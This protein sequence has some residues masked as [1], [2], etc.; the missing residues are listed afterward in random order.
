MERV[1][2]ARQEHEERALVDDLFDGALDP[3]K[4]DQLITHLH[5]C[6]A[7]RAHYANTRKLYR[8]LDRHEADDLGLSPRE[9][10]RML[11]VLEQ[12]R[13][14]PAQRVQPSTARDAARPGR[15]RRM[16]VLAVAAAGALAA[17]AAVLLSLRPPE[18]GEKGGGATSF[19]FDVLCMSRE[20]SRAIV[21]AHGN[22][23]RCPAGSLLKARALVVAQPLQIAV[24]AL[25]EHWQEKLRAHAEASAGRLALF[26]GYVELAPGQSWTFVAIASHTA[27]ADT[28]LDAA[29]AAAR[30]TQPPDS[31]VRL[32]LDGAIEQTVLQVRAQ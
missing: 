14:S 21:S 6:V 3:T 9:V 29:V 25:D 10:D 20:P 1:D 30:K 13:S 27:I 17:A 12:S 31:R 28:A 18:F 5:T 7:C 22:G 15:P 32:K 4:W 2:P 24:V 19:S 8:H 26:D 23:G 16:R 11:E